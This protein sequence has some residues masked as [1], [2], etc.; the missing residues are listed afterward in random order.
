MEPF[1]WAN[2]E[3]L[4]ISDDALTGGPLELERFPTVDGSRWTP[5]LEG[6]ALKE[7]ELR[8]IQDE[9]YYLARYTDAIATDAPRE[10]LHQ[11]YNIAGRGEPQHLLV[12]AATLTSHIEPFSTESLLTRLGAAAPEAEIVTHDLL[13]SYDA[14]Y[15]SR[16]G[17]APLPVL[18]V[19]FDDPMETWVYVDPAMSEVLAAIHRLHRVE[20]WLYNG[21][22]SLDFGFWYYQRPLWDIGMILLCLGALTTSMIGVWL[23][24]R[25]LRRDAARL[26]GRTVPADAAD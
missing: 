10:R 21:L 13:T 17:Q 8:R 1:D 18:R 26:A 4:E 20:R 12:N 5:L 3:G 6:R 15:Y 24:A 11:P 7:L 23:G 19:K 9:P 2:A 22:H 25:R 14:Y 16:G